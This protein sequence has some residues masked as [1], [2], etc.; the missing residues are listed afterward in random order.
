MTLLSKLLCYHRL[1]YNL[2]FI[3]PSAANMH[4]KIGS[5]LAPIMAPAKPLAGTVLAYC[6]L[7]PH[8]EISGKI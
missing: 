3:F 2:K 6:Q 7:D 8:E 4:Q 1:Y 5:A